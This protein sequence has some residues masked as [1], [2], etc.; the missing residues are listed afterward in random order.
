VTATYQNGVLELR[1]P[2]AEGAEPKHIKVQAQ[3]TA[4]GQPSKAGAPASQGDNQGRQANNRAGAPAPE[5]AKK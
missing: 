3:Q 5:K 2:R 4:T 1:I